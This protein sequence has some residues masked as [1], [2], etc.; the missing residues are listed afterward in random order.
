VETEVQNEK[1]DPEVFSKTPGVTT[2][3]ISR[4]Q[5]V[6]EFREA[7]REELEEQA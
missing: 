3:T 2:T 1:I 7:A 4:A 5:K 6:K